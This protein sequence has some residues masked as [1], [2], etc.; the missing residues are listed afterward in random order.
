MQIQ[1]ALADPVL[2]A[3]LS[4]LCAPKAVTDRQIAALAGSARERILSTESAK[5]HAAQGNQAGGPLRSQSRQR[6]R[7][8][9]KYCFLLI[10]HA[11]SA[12]F[13]A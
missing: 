8:L 11:K 7:A 6:L 13:N 4:R 1:P 2:A 10:Y 3:R 9:C 5:Q 12:F